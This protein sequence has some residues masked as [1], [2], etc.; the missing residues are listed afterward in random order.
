MLKFLMATMLS[1]SSLCI[2]GAVCQAQ[3]IATPPAPGPVVPPEGPGMKYVCVEAYCSSNPANIFHFTG[4]HEDLEQARRIAHQLAFDRLATECDASEQ[5]ITEYPCGT[6]V[7]C[8]MPEEEMYATSRGQAPAA[9]PWKVAFTCCCCDGRTINVSQ[10]G[11]CYCE[12]WNKARSYALAVAK[13]HGGA[14]WCRYCIE[15]RPVC[16]SPCC[17]CR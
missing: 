7:F 15:R 14:R 13:R 1:V 10:T 17:G 4:C 16:C 3:D 9:A 11:Q 2:G 12:A 6:T 8:D 5:V